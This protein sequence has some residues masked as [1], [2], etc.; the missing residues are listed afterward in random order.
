MPSPF[1]GAGDAAGRRRPPALPLRRR[2]RRLE[3]A[4]DDRCQAPETQDS[5][6]SSLQANLSWKNRQGGVAL[7]DRWGQSDSTGGETCRRT[8]GSASSSAMM[9]VSPEGAEGQR[10]D[11]E[12]FPD[13]IRTTPSSLYL[14]AAKKAAKL[15]KLPD[16]LPE[17]IKEDINEFKRLGTKSV[18]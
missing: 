10:A 9:N 3:R 16:N 6:T 14:I 7:T 12:Q 8:I 2:Y 5:G 13:L 4:R 17:G 18:F 11:R 15:P 1:L